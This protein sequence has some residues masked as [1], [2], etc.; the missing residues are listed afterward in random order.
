MEYIP[1]TPGIFA[2]WHTFSYNSRKHEPTSQSLPPQQPRRTA[3]HPGGSHHSDH[4]GQWKPLRRMIAAILACLLILLLI[5]AGASWFSENERLQNDPT[6]STRQTI[7]VI[8]KQPAN[9]TQSTRVTVQFT[10][11][12]GKP[13][14]STYQ[15]NGNTLMLSGEVLLLVGSPAHFWLG[16]VSIAS[17]NINS[18]AS[19]SGSYIDPASSSWLPSFL[20]SGIP[21]SVNIGPIRDTKTHTFTILVEPD[22][23]LANSCSLQKG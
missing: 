5:V 12:S 22:S 19:N 17:H 2:N 16:G 6:I 20:L 23:T 21:C 14:T 10:D 3:P 7:E 9:V 15:L 1:S 11:A 13:H 8:V 18:S 4:N